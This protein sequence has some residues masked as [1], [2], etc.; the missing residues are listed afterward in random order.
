V[1]EAAA[2]SAAAAAA[3]AAATPAPA[4]PAA[5]LVAPAIVAGHRTAADMR[6]QAHS[7]QARRHFRN[8][9][10]ALQLRAARTHITQ[11]NTHSYNKHFQHTTHGTPRHGPAAALGAL[12]G[13]G[14]RGRVGAGAGAWGARRRL[15]TA[16]TRALAPGRVADLRS[17]TRDTRDT[18]HCATAAP[19]MEDRAN[20]RRR[21]QHT[22]KAGRNGACRAYD[23]PLTGDLVRRL[24]WRPDWR[25]GRPAPKSACP[26]ACLSIP[27][28]RRMRPPAPSAHARLGAPA[29]PHAARRAAEGGSATPRNA[30]QRPATQ[31]PAHP[32]G[33]CVQLR[34]HVGCAS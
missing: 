24:T 1:A 6:D 22:H 12:C 34:S 2:R 14:R 5:A 20:C 32:N 4:A 21:R 9:Q 29:A 16:N 3:A 15:A 28:A 30:P 19:L 8:R 7:S 17:R 18:A 11:I 13:G 31:R 10:A 23:G 26:P 27:Q 33:R 25:I